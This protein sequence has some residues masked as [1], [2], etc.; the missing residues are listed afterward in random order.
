[1]ASTTVKKTVCTM[2]LRMDQTMVD[3]SDEMTEPK[4][5]VLKTDTMEQMKA[6][7]SV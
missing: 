2:A 5:D 3:N 4:W 1:M 7:S 6:K